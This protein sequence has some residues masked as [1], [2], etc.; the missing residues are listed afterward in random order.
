MSLAG[1]KKQ[2][3]KANQYVSEKVA[4]VKG[5]ELDEEFSEM[6]RK[7]DVMNSLVYEVQARTQE[8]L[9]PN[10][11]SRARLLTMNTISKVRGSGPHPRNQ[12]CPQPEGLLGDCMVKGGRELGED[13]IFGSALIEYGESLHQ[14][15]D[16]KFA[17]EDNVKQNFLDPMANLESKDLREV[18]H[19]R[20]KLSGRRL[21]FDCKRRKQGVP[22][23][24]I[25]AAMDK[26]E[27]T[28][29]LAE[30]SMFNLLENDAEQISQLAAMGQAQ[31]NYHKQSVD[32][33]ER[34][35]DML[36]EKLRQ[37]QNKPRDEHKP[38][39]VASMQEI[40]PPGSLNL[41]N[42]NKTNVD[43]GPQLAPPNGNPRSSSISAPVTPSRQS[44]ACVKA[45]Y[46]FD[47]ENEGEL[48]FREGDIIDLV[49]RLDENWFEGE[50]RGQRG[51]FPCNYVEV[52]I[53]L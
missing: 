24:E 52:I 2:L 48:G 6:E 51:Y 33:L 49:A 19:H 14:M 28:K 1:L 35:N 53:D 9:Q 29:E 32:I 3:N 47:V 17:L 36:Q 50:L 46:D 39:R 45:L 13:S 38:K 40:K 5:T 8:Y 20:K 42:A 4:G 44:R 22:E 23:E 25:K 30:M 18:A 15:S 27:E 26:F 37:A 43:S 16:V 34:L 21:D 7:V 12:T 41:Y 11:A 31:L 10:P